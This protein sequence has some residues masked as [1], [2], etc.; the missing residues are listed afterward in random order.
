MKVE[1]RMNA[2]FPIPETFKA[3]TEAL[4]T[5]SEMLLNRC[6]HP[7]LQSI[8]CSK[9]PEIAPGQARERRIFE[10]FDLRE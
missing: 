10:I 5:A 4:L 8:Q 2:S 7:Q 3:A 9:S 1:K 6:S